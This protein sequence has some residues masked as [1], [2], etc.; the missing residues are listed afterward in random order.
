MTIWFVSSSALAFVPAPIK[1]D[2]E[3]VIRGV[4]PPVI[5]FP[6]SRPKATLLFPNI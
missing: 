1:V 6:A 4:E 3:A 5:V 2:N